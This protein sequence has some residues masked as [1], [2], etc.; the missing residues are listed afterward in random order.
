M[1]VR[2][3]MVNWLFADP[4]ALRPQYHDREKP[5]DY[6]VQRLRTVLLLEADFN[7]G[8]KLP[9]RK[10]MFNAEHLGLLA[11][12]QYGSWKFYTAINQGLNKRLSFDILRQRKQ[13]A[14][15]APQ[16]PCHVMT[17]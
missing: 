7:Q 15:C 10:L 3:T 9:G 17:G 8:N 14:H 1:Y 13:R 16:M 5:G 2:D 11:P 4:M 12:E 6:H